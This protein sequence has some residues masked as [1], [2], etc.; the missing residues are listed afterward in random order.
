MSDFISRRVLCNVANMREIEDPSSELL[1]SEYVRNHSEEGFRE[2]VNRHLALVHSTAARLSHGD[3]HLAEDVSQIV[4][5]DLAKKAPALPPG[6]IVAGWLYQHAWFTTCKMLRSEHRRAGRENEAHLMSEIARE[7]DPDQLEL[8]ALR[9]ELD[10]ALHIL[11]PADRDTLV[12]RFFGDEGLK[13]VGQALGVS[14]DAAQKRVARALE[15]L[16]SILGERGVTLSAAALAAALGQSAASAA[17]LAGLAQRISSVA[18][19]AGGAAGSGGAGALLESLKL[20]AALAGLLGIALCAPFLQQR[21]LSSLARENAALQA[22][23]GALDQLQSENDRLRARSL[24][25]EERA[26]IKADQAELLRLRG[27]VTLLRQ[28][29]ARAVAP[30]KSADPEAA[31]PASPGQVVVEVRVA[32]LRHDLLPVLQQHGFPSVP[33]PR[34]FTINASG[35]LVKSIPA[36]F[37]QTAG[38]DLLSAPRVTTLDGREASISVTEDRVI[39]GEKVPVGITLGVLPHIIQGTWA[40]ELELR[41]T[42]NFL[43]PETEADDQPV[44]RTLSDDLRGIISPGHMLLLGRTPKLTRDVPN[45]ENKLLILCIT[46]TVIDKAGN[47][48]VPNEE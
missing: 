25:D 17:S 5:S 36:L 18:L 3:L 24:S 15:K 34:E 29:A 38:V 9:Q 2:L 44:F 22:S 16:R 21:R 47:A 10:S 33:D 11:P 26:R 28:Q 4:F 39:K 40:T 43:L 35:A 7:N 32:E 6:T 30:Q 12:L 37:Q 13:R 8:A 42:A 48:V 45:A 19:V 41:P 27:E 46:S 23:L 20:K 31:A 14:E 1:L